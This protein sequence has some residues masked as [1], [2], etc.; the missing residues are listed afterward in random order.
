MSGLGGF[1]KQAGGE[2]AKAAKSQAAGY[3]TK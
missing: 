2:V 1:L 3:G